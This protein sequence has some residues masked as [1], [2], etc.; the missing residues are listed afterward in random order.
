MNIANTHLGFLAAPIDPG[1]VQCADV[2][3]VLAQKRLDEEGA[4]QTKRWLWTLG[5]LIAG[6]FFFT[7]TKA[8]KDLAKNLFGKIKGK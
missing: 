4:A 7:K 3:D 5:I 6:G 1:A 8:G 2:I